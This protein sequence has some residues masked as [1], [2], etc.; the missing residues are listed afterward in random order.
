MLNPF[1]IQFLAPFAYFLLRVSLG[2]LMARLGVRKWKK[3]P[4]TSLHA[5]V[6]GAEVVIGFMLAVG[7]FTQ[8]AAII[9]VMLTLPVL[10]RAHTT[11]RALET[12]RLSTFLICLIAFSLFITGA[13]I[14]AFDLPI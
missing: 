1:P 7:F 12:S 8:I 9:T 3:W 6:G 13:G 2:V 14:F 4:Y 11:W 10:V 5:A